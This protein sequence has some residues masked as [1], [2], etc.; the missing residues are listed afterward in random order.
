[1]IKKISIVYD[2][3]QIAE[4]KVSWSMYETNQ[5]LKEGWI[6]IFGGIAHYDNTGFQAKPCWIL[7]RKK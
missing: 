4:T 7:A 6:M 1:M 5:L 2:T 3:E